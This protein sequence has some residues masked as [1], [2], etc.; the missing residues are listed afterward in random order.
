MQDS[1]GVFPVDVAEV[2]SE[3]RVTSRCDGHG[4]R[5]GAA[6]D[7]ATGFDFTDRKDQQRAWTGTSTTLGHVEST[8]HGKVED[9]SDLRL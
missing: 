8:L 3:P 9:P 6:M 4:L 5:P 1:L 2:Y 7:L